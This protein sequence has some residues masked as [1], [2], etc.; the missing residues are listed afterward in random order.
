MSRRIDFQTAKAAKISGLDD[1][2]VLAIAAKESRLLV[3]HDRKTIPK[4]FGKFI[5]SQDCPGVLIVPQKLPVSKVV[6]DLVLIW[7]ATESVEWTNR[8]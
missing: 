7:T 2:D 8:I 3:T 4:H 5:K 6:E 1:E